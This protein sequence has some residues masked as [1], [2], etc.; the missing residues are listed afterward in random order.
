MKCPK[1]GVKMR[2]VTCKFYIGC[3]IFLAVPSDFEITGE[4]MCCPLWVDDCG[5]EE[6]VKP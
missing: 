5:H 6:K 1:C 4:D 3:P 2:C